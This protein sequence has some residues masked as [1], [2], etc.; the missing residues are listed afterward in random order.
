[1]ADNPHIVVWSEIP[2][3]DMER[4]K[5]FYGTVLEQELTDEENAPNP[6]ANFTAPDGAVSGHIYP[7]KPAPKGTG[8][9][10]HLAAPGGLEAT[11]ERVRDAGGE[12]VSPAIDIPP[13]RFF[14]AHDLD[15]NSIGLFEM[16]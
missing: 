13:G 15:G 14:Y 9:T 16:R 8:S 1:M 5:R 7:G 10:V 4:A 6:M 12:V 11:M 2:V 3:T